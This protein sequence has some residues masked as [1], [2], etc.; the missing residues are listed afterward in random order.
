MKVTVFGVQHNVRWHY[1]DQEGTNQR[2][3]IV[4]PDQLQAPDSGVRVEAIKISKNVDLSHISA[5]DTVEIFYNR[6]GNVEQVVKC[7]D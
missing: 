5:G 6:F 3:H 2:L 1:K 7:N 4:Y